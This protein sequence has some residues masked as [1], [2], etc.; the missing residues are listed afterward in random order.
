MAGGCSSGA[1]GGWHRRKKKKKV[2]RREREREGPTVVPGGRLVVGLAT[3]NE[4]GSD[5]G[6]RLGRQKESGTEKMAETGGWGL[7]FSIFAPIFFMLR[8][9]NPILFIGDGRG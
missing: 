1:G 7:F 8:P 6:R 4:A 2:C 3:C 9:W 5:V